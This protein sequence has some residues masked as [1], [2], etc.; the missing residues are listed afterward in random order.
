MSNS[1]RHISAN[2]F[3]S[4]RGDY[5]GDEASVELFFTQSSWVRWSLGALVVKA[6]Y[7]NGGVEL[8]VFLAGVRVGGG[9]FSQGDE[10][11]SLNAQVSL[12][13]AAVELRANFFQRELQASGEVSV[14]GL[15]EWHSQQFSTKILA[16]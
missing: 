15:Q 10:A 2:G 5:L 16:W 8:E 12:T 14:R 9:S 11:L 4:S 6:C 3:C 1:D 7:A 13:K